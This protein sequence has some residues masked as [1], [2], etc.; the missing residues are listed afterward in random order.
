[1]EL[2]FRSQLKVYKQRS[3]FLDHNTHQSFLMLNQQLSIKSH[4]PEYKVKILTLFTKGV[5]RY[6]SIYSDGGF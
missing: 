4:F 2:L 5:Y 1:M 3:F 6:I